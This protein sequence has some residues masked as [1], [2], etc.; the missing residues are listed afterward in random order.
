MKKFYIFLVVAALVSAMSCTKEVN[1]DTVV[2]KETISV[3]LSPET[4]TALEGTKTVWLEGDQVSV[5]VGG[6]VIGTLDFVGEDLFEGDVEAGHDGTATLNYPAGVTS[7]P[8]TQKAV[9]GTFADEAALLEG[10]IS[11]DDLRAGKSTELANKTAL[12]QFSVAQAGDVTFEVGSTKY[13]VTGCET[14]KTYYACVAPE[15][16]KL[17]YT[18]GIVLGAKVKDNFAPVANTVY[19][20]G[21]L[22]LKESEVYGLVGTNNN[23]TDAM[24]YETT[25]DNFYV[26][27]GVNFTSA[28]QFKIRKNNNN[29]WVDDCNFGSA[30]TTT[31]TKN[32]AVGVFTHGSSADIAVNAGTYDV[33][34]DRLASQVY[35]MEPG[36]PYTEATKQSAPANTY[37]S[38]IGKFGAYDWNHDVD[39]N[40]SGDGIWTIVHSFNQ[41]DE[42]KIRKNHGWAASYNNVWVGWENKTNSGENLKM[43]SSGDFIVSFIEKNKSN[44]TNIITLIKK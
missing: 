2:E 9:A 16:G 29:G 14:G 19:P 12:L 27:Y 33:Y 38:L 7:V 25:Q 30:N 10:T 32:T 3:R 42:W 39:L 8:T 11:M 21:E 23:W 37:Y 5:T 26:L 36:K 41:N 24:M 43:N 40:Y 28:G 34:F 13:T 17:S 35:I 4:K 1:S 44:D 15:T 6:S 22:T 31:K 18:V 20:L